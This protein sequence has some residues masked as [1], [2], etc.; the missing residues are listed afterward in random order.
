MN[1]NAAIEEKLE[2]AKKFLDEVIVHFNHE[3]F[4]TA[5]NRIYYSCFHATQALLL[6][7][8]IMP[9]THKGVLKMLHEHFVRNGAFDKAKADFYGEMLN[10]RMESDYGNALL[11][12]KSD[13]E[14]IMQPTKAYVEYV[15]KMV[16]D[17]LAE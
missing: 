10:E 1:K 15:T 13:V 7:K 3:F 5:I 9:K 12:D 16:Q 11:F 4:A 17:Y 6:T 14:D 8:D 2:I